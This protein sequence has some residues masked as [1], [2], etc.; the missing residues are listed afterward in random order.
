MGVYEPGRPSVL[1]MLVRKLAMQQTRAFSGR[2]LF[3]R[4]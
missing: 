4:Y 3:V 1:T 2:L